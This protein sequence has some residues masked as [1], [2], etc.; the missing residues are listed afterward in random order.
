[1]HKKRPFSKKGTIWE[2]YK[3]NE[4]SHRLQTKIFINNK[5]K[6]TIIVLSCVHV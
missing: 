5:S 6:Q 1:M 4:C 3:S 2:A